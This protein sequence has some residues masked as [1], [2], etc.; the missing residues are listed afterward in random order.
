VEEEFMRSILAFSFAFFAL[1]SNAATP[2]PHGSA[3]S[4]SSSTVAMDIA[5]LQSLHAGLT[6]SRDP[7]SPSTRDASAQPSSIFE[8]AGT[9]ALDSNQPSRWLMSLVALLLVSYQLRRKHRSMK[10]QHIAGF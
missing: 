8:P 5:P 7:S 1:T 4:V 3:A 6:S 2:A 10:L 9:Q